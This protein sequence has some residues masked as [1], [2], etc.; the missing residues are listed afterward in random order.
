M[1]LI[2]VSLA[3]V[4]EI[5]SQAEIVAKQLNDNFEALR[6]V[7]NQKN[8]EK[9]YSQVEIDALGSLIILKPVDE[10]DTE[11]DAIEAAS[12]NHNF[13]LIKSLYDNA[14]N[15]D[16][17]SLDNASLF[18]YDLTNTDNT[19]SGQGPDACVVSCNAGY[20]F[21]TETKVVKSIFVLPMRI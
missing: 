5:Q 20:S 15:F 4:E 17:C 12:L 6:V 2:S 10:N 8:I 18:G 9:G 19:I 21:N 16:V 13:N 1:M 3:S 7:A 14:K 11:N